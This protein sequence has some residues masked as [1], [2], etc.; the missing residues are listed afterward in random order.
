MLELGSNGGQKETTCLDFPFPCGVKTR[1]LLLFF[2]LAP[3]VL[4]NPKGAP[5]PAPP[6]SQDTPPT[7]SPKKRTGPPFPISG[8]PVSPL[9]SCCLQGAGGREPLGPGLLH[10]HAGGH[11]EGHLLEVS[12]LGEE[13]KPIVDLLG[14]MGGYG[15]IWGAMGGGIQVGL[16][17]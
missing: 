9:P 5:P 2:R 11:R 15:G 13:E 6:P 8:K 3:F 4:E 1:A 14:A 17:F 10:R 16:W 12:L 7:S